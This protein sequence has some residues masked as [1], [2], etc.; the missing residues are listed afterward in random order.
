MSTPKWDEERTNKLV[1]LAGNVTPVPVETVEKAAEV[2][3]TTT[4]SVA[5]KLRKLNYEVAS[6]A[7][8]HQAA[9]T[10]S[11]AEQLRAFVESN[12][13]KF[14]YADIAAQFLSGKFSTKQI[15][16]KLLSM[17]LTSKVKPTEKVE[18]PR[19]YTEQ[20]ESAFI[21]MVKSGKF[22]EDIAEKLG[23]SI[24]SVRGKALSLLRSGEIAQIPTQRESH[25][26]VQDDA[27][28][29]LG[30]KIAEM[31]VEQIAA[32]AGKTPRGVRTLLTRRG[33][34]CADYDG[35]AKKAKA[36]DAKVAK[37]AKAA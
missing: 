26:K 8:P 19:T 32:E 37:E 21:S 29:L 11:E 3:E 34:V 27:V 28:E 14:T 22:V 6:M 31:T 36:K 33:L 23:K 13:G 30:E 7:K 15:Q 35:A 17:E 25:A 9:F 18:V 24:A 12:A 16:G 4:R 1:K 20:E 2:L 10:T 5:A